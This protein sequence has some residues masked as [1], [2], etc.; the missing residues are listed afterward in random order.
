MVDRKVDLT[1]VH[2]VLQ[3]VDQMVHRTVVLMV[4]PK[5]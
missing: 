1:V 3:M 5:V 4:V 2:L